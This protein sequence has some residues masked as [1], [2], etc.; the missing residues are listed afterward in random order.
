GQLGYFFGSNRNFGL[1]VGLMYFSRSGN[2]RMNTFHMEYK[3][4][5][6]KND[7][8][9]QV[10]TATV[11]IEEQLEFTSISVPLVLKFQERF[12]KKW[13][14]TADVGVVYNVQNKYT[15][16]SGGSFD[17]E[18]VYKFV[19]SGNSLTSV[20]DQSPKPGKTNWLITKD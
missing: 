11:P 1:G 16:S 4:T 5:D 3:A 12:A 2:I 14:F 13:A 6:F 8:F 10:I 9:R 15:Y 20:Y 19:Q 7:V 18:A 17:Y